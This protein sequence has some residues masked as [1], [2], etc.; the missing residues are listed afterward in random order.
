[1]FHIILYSVPLCEPCKALKKWMN[2]NNIAFSEQNMRL[3]DK[4]AQESV[5]E[6]IMTVSRYDHATVPAICIQ[7]RIGEQW[8]SNHGECDVSEMIREIQIFL[9]SL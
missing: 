9:A 3:L 8:I 4:R 2:E 5:K 6:K 7:S 1:M